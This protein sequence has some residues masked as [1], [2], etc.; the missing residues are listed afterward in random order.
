MW[1]KKC[2]T[3]NKEYH[4]PYSTGKWD[5][6]ICSNA[7]HLCRDCVYQDGVKVI[8]CIQCE[9]GWY[10]TRKTLDK[11]LLKFKDK[12]IVVSEFEKWS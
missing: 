5:I 7:F 10:E 2:P 4:K 12:Q 1:P 6:Q 9:E 3:C 11:A 8:K